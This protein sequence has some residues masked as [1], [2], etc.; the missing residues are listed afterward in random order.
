MV[1]GLVG[2]LSASLGFG[3]ERLV[4][5]SQPVGLDPAAVRPWHRLLGRLR[6]RL[7]RLLP[8]LVPLAA[9]LAL[10]IHQH[11]PHGARRDPDGIA[12]SPLSVLCLCV[13]SGMLEIGG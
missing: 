9:V 7:R 6:W 12:F 10:A 11:P 3:I 5:S 8:P 13:A 4:M 1:S 2:N